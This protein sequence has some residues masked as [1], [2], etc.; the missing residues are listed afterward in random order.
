M[1][2]FC[3]DKISKDSPY[4]NL[5]TIDATPYTKAWREF[6]K[7]TPYSEPVMLLEHMSEHNIEYNI[8]NIQD[9]DEYTL[10]PI[11]LSFFDFSIAWFKLMDTELINKL[12]AKHIKILFYYSEG[13]NPHVINDH[14]TQQCIDSNIPREQVLFISANS[15]AANIDYFYYVVDDELL[16]RFRNAKVPAI[17]YSEHIRDKKFT[18]LVRMHKFWRANVMSTIW[19][20]QLDTDGYFAYGDSVNSGESVTDNPVEVDWYVGLRQRTEIF[21]SIVPFKADLLN[22]VE[23]NNHTLC[24][25]EHFSNS[26]INIVLESHM[27][28]DQSG[29]VF[30]TEKTF[31]PIKN[32]QLFVIFGACGSLQKLRDIGYKTFDHVLNNE[33]DTIQD[34]TKRWKA[35]MDMIIT[36][37]RRDNKEIRNMYINCQEDIMHNQTLFCNTKINRLQTLLEEIHD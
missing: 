14:L 3:I 20:Q 16:F 37:L 4:P 23:H 32:S 27:D 11:A 29:G 33:Y 31:K 15:E 35:A 22:N 2:K 21:L 9:A 28:V 18:A 19:Q 24:V 10:Y 7:N 5:A 36:V 13:D 25:G 12:K 26:Y 6:S 8:V 34:T 1:V 17:N 30:L